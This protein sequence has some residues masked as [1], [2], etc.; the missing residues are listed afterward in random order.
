[1]EV[2]GVVAAGVTLGAELLRLSRSLH[3]MIKGIRYARRDIAKLADEMGIF[4]GLYDDFLSVCVTGDQ[5]KS[6]ITSPIVRLISWTKDAKKS[7]QTLL[8]RVRA[9]VHDS[10]HSWIETLAAHVK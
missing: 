7:F 10:R 2:F 1:M 6:R 9:L 3:K 8:D 4:S 5:S